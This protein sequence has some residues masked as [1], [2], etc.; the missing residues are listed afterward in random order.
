MAPSDPD[1]RTK[2]ELIEDLY[3]KRMGRLAPMEN[4]RMLE[5]NSPYFNNNN[6]RREADRGLR[7]NIILEAVAELGLCTVEDISLHTGINNR[8]IQSTMPFFVRTRRLVR[9][10][11]GHHDIRQYRIRD[12]K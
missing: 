10:G 7:R 11:W 1:C 12:G 8:S 4:A 5:F 6:A 2:S 9:I 3:R